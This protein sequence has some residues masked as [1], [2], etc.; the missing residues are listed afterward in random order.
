MGFA[1]ALAVLL[2]L[3]GDAPEF[4]D[5]PV[6][7]REFFVDNDLRVH[8]TTFVAGLMTVFFIIPFAS[9]LRNVLASGEEGD[10]PSWSRLSY[11]GAVLTSAVVL[12]GGSFWEVLG[13]GTAEQLS[14]ETLV[15]LA[16][17]DTVIFIGIMPW[18]LALFIGAA[19]VAILRTPFFS[20]WLGWL[21]A[22]SA[23][24]MVVGTLWLFAEDDTAIIAVPGF[25]GLPLLVLWVLAVGI[26]MLRSQEPARR[27]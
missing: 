9:G 25:V 24:L 14:D 7:F 16:R 13:Q 5:S 23:L 2:I 1:V 26:S 3:G 18:A 21:G 6:E 22:G 10:E 20:R 4:A 11:T 19:S 8:L 15:A 27:C 17:F 12:L